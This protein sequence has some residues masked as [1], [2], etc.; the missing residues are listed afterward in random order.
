MVAVAETWR[1]SQQPLQWPLHFSPLHSTPD[2]KLSLPES[3]AATARVSVHCDAYQELLSL[4]LAVP[5]DQVRE[6]EKHRSRL[7]L[8]L[9]SS[10]RRTWFLCCN[11]SL[12]L[13][14]RWLWSFLSFVQPSRIFTHIL[15]AR[16]CYSSWLT[17]YS[18]LLPLRW[19]LYPL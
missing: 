4:V 7:L 5:V 15:V 17:Q 3:W 14:S 6:D 13:A 2:F 12:S 8:Y 10:G 11:K 9:R 18:L 19:P 16:N 1:T